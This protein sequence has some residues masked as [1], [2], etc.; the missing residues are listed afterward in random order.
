MEYAI[1][2]VSGAQTN[3][4]SSTASE[5][6]LTDTADSFGQTMKADVIFG[7]T[8]T[9]ELAAAGM[10]T[11]FLLKNRYGIKGMK[12]TVGVDKFKQRLF[13]IIDEDGETKAKPKDLVDD[14]VVMISGK[15]K[16]VKNINFE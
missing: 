14:A 2:V 7:V 5:I 6:D 13:N 10:F 3:R 15:K 8:E 9:P 11:F 16:A 1:P 4:G 12:I